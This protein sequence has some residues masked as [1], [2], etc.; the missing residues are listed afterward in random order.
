MKNFIKKYLEVCFW[1]GEQLA[2]CIAL[3]TPIAIIHFLLG[4]ILND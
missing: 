1:M 2:C 4:M 3:F